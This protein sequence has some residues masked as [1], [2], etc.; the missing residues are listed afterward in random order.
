MW[1]GISTT[2]G[3]AYASRTQAGTVNLEEGIVRH[4]SY[5]CIVLVGLA[6]HKFTP[7]A[8][9]GCKEG[10]VDVHRLCL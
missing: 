4:W 5:D 7:P 1:G 3:D 8:S 9:P 2:I 6:A 10:V